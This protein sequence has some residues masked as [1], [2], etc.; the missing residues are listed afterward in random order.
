MK[1]NKTPY[2]IRSDLLH[3][4]HSIVKGR[5]EAEA[6]VNA[7]TDNN[8]DLEYVVKDAPTSDEI[9]AEATKLNEFVSQ[10]S[11]NR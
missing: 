9:I 3:L 1:N 7:S 10:S 11:D 2:E 5:K 4:A 8:G 6:A